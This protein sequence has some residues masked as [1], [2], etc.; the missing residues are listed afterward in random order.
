MGLALS[1][2]KHI[3]EVTGAIVLLV[4]HS[5]KDAAKGARG[6]SGIRAAADTEIEI[7]GIHGGGKRKYQNNAMVKIM[8]NSPLNSIP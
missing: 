1:H 4:H 6:W 7:V 2:C 3:Y 5:G 8:P